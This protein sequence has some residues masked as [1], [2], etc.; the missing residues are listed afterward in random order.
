MN[1]S[2]K[3]YLGFSLVFLI[4]IACPEVQIASEIFS[5]ILGL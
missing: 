4:I 1:I 5:R 2:I 3:K